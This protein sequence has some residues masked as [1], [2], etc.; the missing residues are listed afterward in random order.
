MCR[1]TTRAE[2]VPHKATNVDIP[3]AG[4]D[5]YR[6]SLLYTDRL[7]CC[8]PVPRGNDGSW[9]LGGSAQK[10]ARDYFV[11][12]RALPWWAVLFS[13]VATETGALTFISI[14]GLAYSRDLGFLQVAAGYILGRAVIAVTLLPRYYHGDL[15]TA[16]ALLERRFGLATR[17]FASIVFMVTRAMA[18][19]VR[20]FATAIPVALILGFSVGRKWRCLW[21]S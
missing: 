5:D 18:D 7:R 4:I 8:R 13:I 17:R 1:P 2:P 14:P 3:Y 12:D 19:S 15:V 16:Y 9:D 11:A 6:E 21:R 20:M 10:D